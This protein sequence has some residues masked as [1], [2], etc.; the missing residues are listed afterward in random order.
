M[1]LSVIILTRNEEKNIA[2][3][4]KGARFADEIIVI[5]D[6]SEDKT[7]EIAKKAGA[8]VYSRELKDDFAAQRN[9][10]LEKASSRWVLFVDPDEKVPEEL[11]NEI[12]Q[13]IKDSSVNYMGFYLKRTDFMWGKQLKH[14]EIGDIRLLRLARRKAGK[15]RR[16]VHEYWDVIG[17]IGSLENPLLHSPHP[18]LRE[19][20][21]SI[22]WM[23]G[24]HAQ[25][26][27]EEGKKSSLI[28][29]IAWPCGKFV[30]NY[31][32]RLGFLDG[33]QGLVFALMMSFH[34]FLAWS[35]LWKS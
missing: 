15:W 12:V 33:M 7:V 20:I 13:I 8:K 5:D 27:S 11:R 14:G 6:N 24:L 18:T 1:N 9:F 31:I 32:L 19:F 21:K 4:I 28:K 26:N 35:K 16:R 3:C 34:S 2:V 23:S 10:G 29:I 25:A 30:Y 17:R 22:N